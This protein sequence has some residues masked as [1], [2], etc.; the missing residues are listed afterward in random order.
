MNPTPSSIARHVTPPGDETELMAR[1][2]QWA[3]STLD[4]LAQAMSVYLPEGFAG[5]KGRVGE[6]LE[7]A[8][9]AD[10]GSAPQPDFQALGIEL[11]TLPVNTRGAPLESTFVTSIPLLNIHQ[12]T[13]A[14]STVW[15]KLQRVLWIPI[16]TPDGASLHERIIGSPMLWSPTAE[17]AALLQQ[18]WQELVDKICLGE[19][20]SI[21][22]RMGQVLQVRPKAANSKALCWAINHDGERIQTLPRGFYLRAGFTQEILNAHFA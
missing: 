10:A 4:S 18:D 7:V 12:E 21:H 3:G 6:L 2:Q 9:G 5:H 17:Q 13:W 16:I 19:L 8:L 15:R 11:K 22:A 20:E 14:T 1:A